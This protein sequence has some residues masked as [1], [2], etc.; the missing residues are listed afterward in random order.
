MRS[1]SK[2]SGPARGMTLMLLA[3]PGGKVRRFQITQRHLLV[4]GGLW[5]LALTGFFSL[6]FFG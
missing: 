2:K 5:L 3:S 6:G 1:P 4:V